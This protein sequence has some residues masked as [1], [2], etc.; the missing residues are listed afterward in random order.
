M[1]KERSELSSR[2]G[3]VI[4]SCRDRLDEGNEVFKGCGVI[5]MALVEC[6][7]ALLERFDRI[8]KEENHHA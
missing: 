4:S 2:V 7:E 1:P 5:A 6:T 3:Q 8:L